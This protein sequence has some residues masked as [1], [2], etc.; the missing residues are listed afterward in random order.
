MGGC[1]GMC[2]GKCDGVAT[3]SGGMA[4]CAGTCEGRC[5]QP[6]LGA[7][8]R[9]KCASSCNGK[10]K[11]ECKLDAM[12]NVNCGASVSCKGGCTGTATQPK[13]ET[14]L[15]PP[16]CTGDPNCQSSCSAEASAKMI[17]TPLTVTL[18]ANVE[19][20]GDFAKLKAT[21]EKNLPT[22]L[23]TARTKGQLAARALEKVAATGQAVVKASTNFGG[24][25][26]ACAGTAAEAALTASASMSVSVNASASVT[27]SCTKNSS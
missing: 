23:I 6:A 4:N 24:K 16:V 15:I 26:I 27:S 19:T 18:I 8:C 9:G 21:I 11:G 20:S 3:P 2:E 10:C 7:S 5:T 12:A 17:C 14:E 25:A 22:I 13:C 1:M